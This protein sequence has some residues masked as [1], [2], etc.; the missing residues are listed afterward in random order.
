MS[1]IWMSFEKAVGGKRAKGKGGF[2]KAK[3]ALRTFAF[4][5]SLLTNFAKL[6]P[7]KV[8]LVPNKV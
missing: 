6:V 3:L 7:N 1:Y 4:T 8:K 5:P 2:L